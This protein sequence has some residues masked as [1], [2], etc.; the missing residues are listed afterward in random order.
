MVMSG[1]D[2]VDTIVVRRSV[3]KGTKTIIEP[4]KSM[5]WAGNEFKQEQEA[6]LSKFGSLKIASAKGTS[7]IDLTEMP[8]T[9]VPK[10][11]GHYIS[12]RRGT[13]LL[14]L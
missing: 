12:T 7:M 3:E 6:K 10:L 8:R 11:G 14:R 2:F 1:I 13:E 4:V 9:T 5:K